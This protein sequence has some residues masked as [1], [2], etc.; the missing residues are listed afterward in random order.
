V[1][2]VEEKSD[3]LDRELEVVD[4]LDDDVDEVEKSDELDRELEVVDGLDD[5]V[6]EVEEKSDELDRELEVVD[7]RLQVLVV[8]AGAQYW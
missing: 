7:A 8:A 3:E 1:D 5:D 4:G 6:G 2:E